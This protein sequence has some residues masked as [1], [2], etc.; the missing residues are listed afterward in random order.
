MIDAAAKNSFNLKIE[1]W[2]RAFIDVER[3]RKG[4]EPPAKK[5]L[6]L[7]G[8]NHRQTAR[9]LIK[10]RRITSKDREQLR[11]AVAANDVRRAKAIERKMR[12]KL[13]DHSKAGQP[14]FSHV[15]D[16]EKV[17]NI[18]AIYYAATVSDL[19]VGPPLA[20]SSSLKG[21]NRKTVPEL[22]EFGGRATVTSY[23]VEERNAKGK[24]VDRRLRMLKRPVQA[25]YAPRPFMAPT[26][27]KERPRNVKVLARVI[28]TG[29]RSAF[30]GIVR[31]D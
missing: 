24:V 5:A 15:G 12:R 29:M 21:S 23:V 16:G 22:L 28:G 8:R 4:L 27:E 17:A 2:K 11:E 13:F 31:A 25:T 20:N 3:A 30:S 1:R 26:A 7:I 9:K 6:S 18:R 10:V 19:V 14:P